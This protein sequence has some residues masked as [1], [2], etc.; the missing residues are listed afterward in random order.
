MDFPRLLFVFLLF[1]LMVPYA[2][3]EAARTSRSMGSGESISRASYDEA[4]GGKYSGSLRTKIKKLDNDRVDDIPVPVLFVDY[5]DI[6]PDFGAPRDGGKRKHQGQDIL[7]PKN[8]F[9]VSPTDAVV[10][11]IGKGE[12]A[13]IYVYTA[14]PGG[15]VFAYMHLE[16]IAPG[17]KRGSVLAPGDL[18]GFVGNTGNARYTPSH[19][20]F[21][22][23]KG[24][25]PLDPYPRLV[26]TFTLAEQKTMLEGILASLEKIK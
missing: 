3:A 16:K 2:P 1:T 18:I 6:Y 12:S 17:L 11:K 23:R 13:G 26:G 9:I 19:L 15:E 14:N 24:R 7:A 21:E 4:D 22:I 10:T 8:S 5:A 20:H 25:K